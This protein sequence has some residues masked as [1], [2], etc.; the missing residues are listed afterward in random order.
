MEPIK[1]P[2]WQSKVAIFNLVMAL[3]MLIAVFNPAA[4]AFLKDN[5]APYLAETGAAW[6]I[7]NI[8]LRMLKSNLTF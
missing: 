2:V 4:G 6:G 8:V 1:K 7:I 5:V 3:A